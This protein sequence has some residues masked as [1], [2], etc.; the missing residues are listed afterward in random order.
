M[1]RINIKTKEEIALMREAGKYHAEM[2]QIVK[3]FIKAGV[4]TW[5]ID[6]VALDFIK[7]NDLDPVQIGYFG[8]PCA[9][10]VGVNDN[11][12]HA[13]PR[14]D[15]I[16]KNGDIVTF[17]STIR[18]N[19]FCADGGFSV[20]IGEIDDKAKTLLET[21]RH[22]LDSA[23]K[24]CKIGNHVGDIGFTI[25]VLAQAAG[26]D[27]LDLFTAHGI[28]REMHEEP[29]IPNW[30]ELGSGPVIKE[31]MTFAMDTL[32]VEGSGQV[33]ILKDGWTTK[34]KD[35]GRFG[36]FEHTVAITKDGAEIL[37]K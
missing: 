25:Y 16:L 29:E 2:C 23:I 14:K 11:T 13:I 5:D 4:S 20:G 24:V 33:D 9:T 15:V 31:G 28:G 30:G 26:F 1:S 8:Y 36:F 7:K 10:C 35:G 21:T 22:A 34:T 32:I 12:V 18:K 3:D 27:T 37:T 6:Q 17:D 19:G